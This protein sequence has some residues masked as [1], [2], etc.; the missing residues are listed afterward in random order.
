MIVAAV[1]AILLANSVLSHSY[2]HLTH[3]PLIAGMTVHDMVNDVLMAI[4][5]FAV[6]MELKCEMREG[7]LAQPG[8]KIL[9]LMAALGG[10]AI[11]AL[12][13]LA[14]THGHPELHQGWAIPAAT[15]I[16]FALCVLRLVGPRISPSAITFLLAIAIY[17]DLAAIVIIALCYAGGIALLPLAAATVL[18]A[19]LYALNR[20][21][22]TLLTPY[23]IAGM[24]LW[25]A[26]AQA[27]VH[28]T[29]AG[30]ITGVAIP[31]RGRN[32]TPLLA[33]LLHRVHP[34][35]TILILPMFAFVS[36]GVDLREVTL[37][38]ALSALPIGIALA[39]FM[40]KQLGVFAATRLAVLLRIA[41]LPSGMRW[42]Q[43]YGIA[44]LAGIGF[45]MSLF[46]GQL[47]FTTPSM[48]DEVKIGVLAGSLLSSVVGL[49]FL[50]MP[51]MA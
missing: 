17:D 27:G 47:A 51:R 20:A 12:I 39:L 22:I 26:M 34:Y 14:I 33:P 15:D 44:I 8:Q 3:L 48:Q 4:F 31:M 9:P 24:L 2:Q 6:G 10:M 13:Y 40:G 35:V 49:F 43:A 30:V 18:V 29:I 36:A 45:T 7:T 25:L 42:R 37:T 32:Q 46:I 11:P 1:L 16:A 28:P 21:H 23:L 41:P 5:F 38:N 50:R 19:I